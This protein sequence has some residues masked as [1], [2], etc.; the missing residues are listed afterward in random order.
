[1]TDAATLT[2]DLKWHSPFDRFMGEASR[3]TIAGDPSVENLLC[4]LRERHP[5]LKPFARWDAGDAKA[6][7]LMV[8]RGSDILNLKDVLRPGDRLEMLAMLEGG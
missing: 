6:W 2:I 7:G 3:E 1:M 5:R 4:R 8:L